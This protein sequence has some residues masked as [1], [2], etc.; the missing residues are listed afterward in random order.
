MELDRG[1]AADAQR[2][3]IRLCLHHPPLCTLRI[4]VDSSTSDSTT[5]GERAPA[6]TAIV[7]RDQC[8]AIAVLRV[9]DPG[10]LL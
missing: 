5:F 6:N 3:V 8:L 2:N 9:D 1:S 10:R 4:E 7:D